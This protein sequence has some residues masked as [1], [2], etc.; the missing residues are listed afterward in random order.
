M[1]QTRAFN[2]TF[3]YFYFKFLLENKMFNLSAGLYFLYFRIFFHTQVTFVFHLLDY[4]FVFNDHADAF[5]FFLFQKGFYI[6]HEGIYAFGFFFFR[7]ILIHFTSLFMKTFLVFFNNIL[8]TFLYIEKN[9][10]RIFYRFFIW[11]T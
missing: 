9:C 3:L 5:C 2:K 7:N 1:D 8:L 4:L 10:K 11:F 6:V